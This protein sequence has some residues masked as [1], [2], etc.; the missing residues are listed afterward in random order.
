MYKFAQSIV[1]FYKLVAQLYSFRE[2]ILN[3]SDHFFFTPAI[4]FV[5]QCAK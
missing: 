2:T 5:L 4:Y 1:L 3:E